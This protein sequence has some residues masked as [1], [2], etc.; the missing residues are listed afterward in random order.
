MK[1]FI[2]M[3]HDVGKGLL[4]HVCCACC[5]CAPLE[6]FREEGIEVTGYFYNP[7][8]H[9]LLEFRRW[10][11][12]L[13]VFQESDHIQIT[14]CEDYGLKDYLKSVDYEGLDRCK[15]CYTLRVTETARYAKEKG[16]NSFSSTL[17]FSVHQNHEQIRTLCEEAATRYGV[18]FEYRDYRQLSQESHKIAKKKMLYQQSYCG[19]IFSEYERYKDTTRFLYKKDIAGKE[20]APTESCF[21]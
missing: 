16:F 10:L 20:E 5:L 8:I 7:N 13:R 19:C 4:L 18:K 14:Y 12:A 15:D 11:K 3:E 1:R 9:P 6:A 2:S 17:L 21:C